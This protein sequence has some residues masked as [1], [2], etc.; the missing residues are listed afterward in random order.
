MFS[1]KNFLTRQYNIYCDFRKYYTVFRP[2]D[3]IY[4]NNKNITVV[5]GLERVF[6][7]R[8]NI[9]LKNLE[10]ISEIKTKSQIRNSIPDYEKIYEKD[11]TVYAE[12]T[13]YNAEPLDTSADN[14]K[15]FS[16]IKAICNSMNI[17]TCETDTEPIILLENIV[18]EKNEPYLLHFL[19]INFFDNDIKTLRVQLKQAVFNK[20]YGGKSKYTDFKKHINPYETI[21]PYHPKILE[22]ISKFLNTIS[23]VNQKKDAWKYASEISDEILHI[24]RNNSD[25]FIYPY[26]PNRPNILRMKNNHFYINC[27]EDIYNY[28]SKS[29]NK[30]FLQ[31]ENQNLLE[32][33]ADLYI[34]KSPKKYL[35]IIKASAENG[36]LSMLESNYFSMHSDIKS[37]PERLN[38][39]YHM[40][41]EGLLLIIQKCDVENDQ[42]FKNILKLPSD[43]IFLIDKDYSQYGFTSFHIRIK[44]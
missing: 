44:E 42:F 40:C 18:F 28:F 36:L 25:Y 11:G 13:F 17:L 15:F 6:E 43:I 5:Q 27:I 7:K 26:V 22:L 37:A 10:F 35:H 1:N 33:I 16:N 12:S 14:I 9:F 24:L 32:N 34:I 20:I 23:P 31:S 19:H 39:L 2:L 3:L 21:E 4:R 29:G 41:S 8:K 38:K 30:I